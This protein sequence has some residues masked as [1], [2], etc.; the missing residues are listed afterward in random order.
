MK[1]LAQNS[2]FKKEDFSI[3]SHHFMANRCGKEE[4]MTGFIF[5]GSKITEDG[6]CSHEIKRQLLF[7]RKYVTNLA[8]IQDW[9]LMYTSGR[10]MF[11]YAKTNTVL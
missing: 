2:T 3:W 6:D 9:E 8:S 11:M 1:K 7:G 4:T 5:F 10:F